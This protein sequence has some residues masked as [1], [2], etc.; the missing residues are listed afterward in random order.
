MR[1][2]IQR[3]L[4]FG[5]LSITLCIQVSA[6]DS[7]ARLDESWNRLRVN[8][9]RRTD[10]IMNLTQFIEKAGKDS[11]KD[12][13]AIAADFSRFLDS[14]KNADSLVIQI[15]RQKEK[16]FMQAAARVLAK[17]NTDVKFKSKDEFRMLQTQLEGAE[18]R[19]AM[20]K[21]DHNEICIRYNRKDL[22]YPTQ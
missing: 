3:L 22:L 20:A 8:F 16:S 21:R 2:F 12:V 6:Q 17:F 15:S 14:A 1:C 9:Q 18:N 19:I 13:R 5:F 10:L 7:L 4:V 11:A